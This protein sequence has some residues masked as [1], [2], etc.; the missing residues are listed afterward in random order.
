MTPRSIYLGEFGNLAT[1]SLAPRFLRAASAHQ[2]LLD[3]L[4]ESL[5]KGSFPHSL[6][7][8]ELSIVDLFSWQF[9]FGT[10]WARRYHS[11]DSRAFKVSVWN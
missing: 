6:V 11:C 4:P 3:W 7:L 10:V 5:E 2:D 9:W 1:V 8:L